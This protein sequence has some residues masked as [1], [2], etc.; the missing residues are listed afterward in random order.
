MPMAAAS[1]RRA[2]SQ[3]RLW[4]KR[5][6]I[7]APIIRGL[8]V[9]TIRTTSKRDASRSFN[10]PVLEAI[11]ASAPAVIIQQIDEAEL[12]EMGSYVGNPQAP[13][14]GSTLG[15]PAAFGA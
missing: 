2:V 6:F 10:L 13:L 1:I 9:I 3:P 7:C 12:D 11:R 14:A 8:L 4:V 15:R 5:P